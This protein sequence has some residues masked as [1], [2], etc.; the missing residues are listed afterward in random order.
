ML[1]KNNRIHKRL[2][3]LLLNSLS[4]TFSGAFGSEE[5]DAEEAA[6]IVIIKTDRGNSKY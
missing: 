2:C 4:V 5:A 6:S 1:Q 3:K